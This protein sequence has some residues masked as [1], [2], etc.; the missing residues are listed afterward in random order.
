MLFSEF[1]E[2]LDQFDFAHFAIGCLEPGLRDDLIRR[3]NFVKSLQSDYTP[4][5]ILG[6][7]G[8]SFN[9]FQL[10]DAV[11]EVFTNNGSTEIIDSKKNVWNLSQL[12]SENQVVGK[13]PLL[14]KATDGV[15]IRLINYEPLATEKKIRINFLKAIQKE[16]FLSEIHIEKWKIIFQERYLTNI[17]F[18]DFFKF[19]MSSP[20]EFIYT[21]KNQPLSE[22][23]F[24]FFL[25]PNSK[26][27][28]EQLIGKY[29]GSD[30][31][32]E[33]VKNVARFHISELLEW[34]PRNGLI[35]CL[36][37]STHSAMTTEICSAIDSPKDFEKV[38]KLLVNSEDTVSQLGA[39][40]IGMSQLS[41]KPN[42]EPYIIKLIEQLRDDDPEKIESVFNKLINL[43]VFVDGMLSGTRCLGNTP[44][45]YRRMASFAHATQLHRFLMSRVKNLDEFFRMIHQMSAHLYVYQTFSD[46]K[47]D[48]RSYPDFSNPIML[49]NYFLNQ[50]MNHSER[51]K[52]AGFSKK[53]INLITGT[54]DISLVNSITLSV[55][56]LSGPID[57]SEFCINEVPIEIQEQQD[58]GFEGWELNVIAR[59]LMSWVIKFDN[60]DLNKYIVEY[61]VE[62]YDFLDLDLSNQTSF[63]EILN[64]ISI[65]AAIVK[66]EVLTKRVKKWCYQIRKVD[67]NLLNIEFELQFCLVSAYAFENDEIRRK[68]IGD[69]ITDLSFGIPN[70]ESKMFFIGLRSLCHVEP[71]MWQYCSRAD[72]ALSSFMRFWEY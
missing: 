17:E 53:L 8:P 34:H 45:F 1:I 44:P 51:I 20:N 52:Y 11:R 65:I 41:K 16:R 3:P 12:K 21:I 59:V 46:L 6:V 71:E 54:N 9:Q 14:L 35:H 13:I 32:T 39:I 38:L 10:F 43:F 55:N 67:Q 33:Y 68:F 62:N 19:I 4:N 63:I 24:K 61:L 23:F 27:Y 31:I 48:P 26:T 72:A 50:I 47:S 66:S 64:N 30:S 5:T 18:E 40:C 60:M 37:L 56:N 58:V 2:N 15:E 49:K 36:L 57:G 70:N 28:Y 69:W 29:D 25:V 42:Y 22:R 7:N